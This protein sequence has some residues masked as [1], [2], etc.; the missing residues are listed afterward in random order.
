[1]FIKIFCKRNLKR[2]YSTAKEYVCQGQGKY[3]LNEKSTDA[4]IHN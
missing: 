1:M 4:Q 3:I 2:M